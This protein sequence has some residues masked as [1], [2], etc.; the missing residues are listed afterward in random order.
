MFCHCMCSLREGVGSPERH[1]CEGL[2]KVHQK[3]TIDLLSFCYKSDLG[4]NPER[5]KF[6]FLIREASL[7]HYVTSV[8]LSNTVSGHDSDLSE[9]GWIR[10]KSDPP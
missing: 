9:R 5:Q 2:I 7:P 6:L 4:S 3:F 1:S 8:F 10:R